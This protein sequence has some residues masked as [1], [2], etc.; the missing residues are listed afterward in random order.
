MLS[1]QFV[2]VI[3]N[4]VIKVTLLMMTASAAA[5]LSRRA[6]ASFR[7]LVWTL[8]L[9]CAL[10]FASAFECPSALAGLRFYGSCAAASGRQNAA[11]G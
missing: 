11:D 6:S 7:H 10:G 4:A 8:G 3:L 5:L 2:F 9:G 1:H